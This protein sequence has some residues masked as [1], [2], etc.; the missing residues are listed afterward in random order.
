MLFTGCHALSFKIASF[1]A[2]HWNRGKY[3]K[4]TKHSGKFQL[5]GDRPVDYIQSVTVDLNSIS[6]ALNHSV[7]LPPICYASMEDDK[8]LTPEGFISLF[9]KLNFT[10]PPFAP[11]HFVCF[12]L[13]CS[14]FICFCLFHSW[15]WRPY[16][17][18]T[19]YSK[20][21]MTSKLD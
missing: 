16:P 2:C 3:F 20:T 7:T 11:L 13:S 15:H 8:Q 5:A 19:S 10:L 6:I 1:Q 14:F 17:Q 18:V 4:W 21:V 12:I 9:I